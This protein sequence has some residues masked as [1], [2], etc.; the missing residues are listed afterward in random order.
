MKLLI[1][2]LHYIVLC[3]NDTMYFHCIARLVVLCPVMI[4][5]TVLAPFSGL[6]IAKLETRR[7]FMGFMPA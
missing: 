5:L 1:Q 6:Y 7:S 3:K 2:V 4:D